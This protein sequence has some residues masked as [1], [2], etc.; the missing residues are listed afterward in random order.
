ME[1]YLHLVVFI[2]FLVYVNSLLIDRHYQDTILD[3]NPQDCRQKGGEF[4]TENK[5]CQCRKNE[6]IFAGKDGEP[7]SCSK[8]QSEGCT[9]NIVKN[10]I[11]FSNFKQKLTTQCKQIKE[12]HLWN[13]LVGNNTVSWINVTKK[14]KKYFNITTDSHIVAKLDVKKWSGQ[15]I[16]LIFSCSNEC[17]MLKVKGSVQYPINEKRLFRNHIIHEAVDSDE[18]MPWMKFGVIVAIVSTMVVLCIVIVIVATT[19]SRRSSRR[20]RKSIRKADGDKVLANPY[21]I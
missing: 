14:S 7:S 16:K 15:L 6:S 3:F 2:L 18:D 10:L 8:E 17:V 13:I 5:T 1:N 20:R 9:V 4:S 12:I 19:C 21:S 11:E